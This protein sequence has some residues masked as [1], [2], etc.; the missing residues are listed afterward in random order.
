MFRQAWIVS[1]GNRDAQSKSPSK[2][3]I[4]AMA[5]DDEAGTTQYDM[6]IAQQQAIERGNQ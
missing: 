4:L 1:T 6:A 2:E 3:I 5:Q